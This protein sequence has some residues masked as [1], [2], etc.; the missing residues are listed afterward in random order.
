M[1]LRC[2][3]RQKNGKEHRT[4]SLVESRRL[5]PGPVVPRPV[6]YLGEINDS[7]GL[8][9]R[10]SVEL[11]AEAEPA[12]APITAA[13]IPEEVMAA[14][15]VGAEEIV[16]LRRRELQWVRPRQWGACWLALHLGQELGLDKFWA[17]RLLPSRKG[18]RWDKVLAVLACYRLLS[19]GSEWRLPR[20]WFLRSA[21]AD[22]LGGRFFAGRG[23]SAL[24]VPRPAPGTPGGIV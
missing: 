20:E 19:P 9:W 15:S 16:R 18:T 3:V 4:W 11:F 7:Q 2:K 8:A 22:L 14:V 12:R 13:L 17:E 10:K 5:S 21:L 23:T 6:L 1:F 24:R